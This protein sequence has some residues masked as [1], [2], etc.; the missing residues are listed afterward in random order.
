MVYFSYLCNPRYYSW[1]LV[2]RF[3]CNYFREFLY[4]FYSK[5]R[6]WSCFKWTWRNI[7]TGSFKCNYGRVARFSCNLRFFK[8]SW[9][10]GYRTETIP[11]YFNFSMKQQVSVQT[12]DQ[13]LEQ[14]RFRNSFAVMPKGDT[15][16]NLSTIC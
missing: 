1:K 10:C 13:L 12:V 11:I 15:F 9:I 8:R 6:S 7:S 3:S 16:K 2:F 4:L 5:C 14:A